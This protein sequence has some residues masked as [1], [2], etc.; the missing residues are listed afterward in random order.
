M[1]AVNIFGRFD[2]S[3][4]LLP[5]KKSEAVKIQE[6]LSTN[7]LY[8]KIILKEYVP[9]SMWWLN[10]GKNKTTKKF[11]PT[12]S[13]SVRLTSAK[14]Y[15]MNVFNGFVDIP[16]SHRKSHGMCDFVVIVHI[17]YSLLVFI[18]WQR[19]TRQ[20]SSF[21]KSIR[22]LWKTISMYTISLLM[23]ILWKQLMRNFE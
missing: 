7:P 8:K 6:C 17:I 1:V 3:R 16:N 23:S 5:M 2:I 12:I 10:M 20:S 18:P 15:L 11:Q 9:A 19:I 14:D 21:S 22:L 4:N 13:E